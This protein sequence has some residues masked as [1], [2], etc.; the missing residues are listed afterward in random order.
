MHGVLA[1]HQILEQAAD[2]VLVVAAQQ[3]QALAQVF[4]H[5]D[6]QLLKSGTAITV[7][8]GTAPGQLLGDFH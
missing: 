8:R 3:F 6:A 1:G 5:G 2:A 4:Q 7:L